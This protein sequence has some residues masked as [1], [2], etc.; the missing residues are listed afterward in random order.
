MR[1]ADR[2]ID[3]PAQIEELLRQGRELSLAMIDGDRPYVVRMNY[4]YDNNAIYLHCAATGKKIDCLRVNPAVC[5]E[6]SSVL[7]R[8]EGSEAC[9]WSTKY[10]SLIGRGRV[11]LIEND[12]E[13]VQGYDVL[14][15]QFGGPEG[16][17]DMNNVRA[18]LILRIDIDELT[19]KQSN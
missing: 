1:R 2:Q 10:S 6:I 11:T 9:M 4:G 8:I 16:P 13:K 15:R 19:A 3:D 14:M 18:T 17:Y 7:N 5:F 12:A